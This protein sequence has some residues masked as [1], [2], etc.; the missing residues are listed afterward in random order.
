ML[1][2]LR[3]LRLP[4]LRGEGP[5][6]GTGLGANP[7]QVKS[8]RLRRRAGACSAEATRH[9]AWHQAGAQAQTGRRMRAIVQREARVKA[10]RCVPVFE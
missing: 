2:V 10:F 9:Q 5:W 1:R 6:S 8:G 4:G 7:R 3:V